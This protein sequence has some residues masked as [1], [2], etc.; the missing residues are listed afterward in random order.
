MRVTVEDRPEAWYSAKVETRFFGA[1]ARPQA[2]LMN[3]GNFRGAQMQTLYL[4]RAEDGRTVTNDSVRGIALTRSAAN[5]YV[6]ESEESAD[7]ERKVYQVILGVTLSIER[8]ASSSGLR[9]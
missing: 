1:A 8:C 9:F 3:A 5:S 4:L 2:P 6:W 7:R